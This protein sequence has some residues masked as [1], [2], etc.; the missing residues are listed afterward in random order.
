M[1]DIEIGRNGYDKLSAQD[2][3]EMHD[4]CER[5]KDYLDR[6]KT[7]RLCIAHSIE[8]AEAAGF[9]PYEEDRTYRAGDKVYSVSREKNLFLAVIGRKSLAHGANISVAHTDSPRLDVEPRP[10]AED[11]GL[12]YFQTYLYGWVRKHQWL[13]RPLALHGV[14]YRADGSRCTVSLGEAADEPKFM[15]TDLLPHLAA[16]QNKLPFAEV[17]PNERMRIIIGSRPMPACT[18]RERVL[19][20]ALQLL[21]EKYGI[22]EDDLLSAELELVPAGYACDIGFDRSLIASYGQDDR[23][24]AFAQLSALFETACP[25]RTVVCVLT[26]K[27]EVNSDGMTG[28]KS[29]AFDRFMKRL[30]RMQGVDLDDCYANSFCISADV[31]A[32]YDPNYP[33]VFD[34]QTAAFVNRGVAVSTYTGHDGDKSD[35]SDASAEVVA[36]FRTIMAK[37]N[38]V[39]QLNGMGR[40]QAGGGGTI[41]KYMANRNIDTL[42]AGVPVLSMHAPY[43]TTA[44]LDCYM[45]YRAL[46]AVFAD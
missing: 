42:D 23:V 18:E 12:A 45:T 7:E 22:A 1:T 31:T 9:R 25:E 34:V 32:A 10:T 35:A 36:K 20:Q 28:M 13:A 19:A 8:L 30:C 3:Q 21:S 39:W 4:Y 33:D 15:I 14:V 24:C 38:V 2:L 43:E 46:R 26:D 40:P 44:K 17:Y 5:Y 11:G 41:A 16:A 27:E 37:N 6:C 29:L